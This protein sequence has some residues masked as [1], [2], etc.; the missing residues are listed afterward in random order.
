MLKEQRVVMNTGLVTTSLLIL[1]VASFFQ[2]VFP[3]A[4]LIICAVTFGFAGAL[5]VL[6]PNEVFE[7][8]A[9]VFVAFYA[10]RIYKLGNT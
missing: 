4:S 8:L 5:D 9:T 10:Y 2:N 6:L 3:H 7:A 1:I